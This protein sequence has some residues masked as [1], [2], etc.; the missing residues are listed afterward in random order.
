MNAAAAR[1]RFDTSR[2][3]RLA[4]VS[5]SGRPHLVPITFALLGDETIVSAVDHKPKRTEA[6]ARLANVV[7]NPAVCVLADH[8]SEQWDELWWARADGH[9]RVL[10]PGDDE[11]ARAAAVHA[12]A[13]RYGHYR[14]R[15]PN[16]AVIIVTVDRW[17]AW[18]AD[19]AENRR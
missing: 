7:A 9:A 3:A 8:Y 18:S 19:P 5:A 11:V 17:S 14:E 1:E 13:Q 2:V 10:K 6:L 16:G 4:T 12:L 15:P